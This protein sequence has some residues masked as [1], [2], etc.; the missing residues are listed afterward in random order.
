MWTQIAGKIKLALAPMVN[1]WWQVALC[2][3]TRGLTTAP[4]PY[5]H[6]SFQMD[7]D[8]T[9]HELRIT[10][11]DGEVRSVALAPRSVADFYQDV[12]STLSSLG[13]GVRIWTTPVEV[14]DPIPFDQDTV[15]ASYDPEYAHR[16]WR[17]LWQVDRVFNIFRSSFIGKVSPVN[18]YWGSFDLAI[19]RFSGR[20]A[21]LHPSVPF[22]AD[23]VVQE[24][25]SHQES[26]CGFWPGGGPVP[27]PVFYS[28]AYPGPPGFRDAPLRPDAASFNSDLAE[29]ILPYD[30]VR[31]ADSPD[32]LLLQFL[33]STYEAAANTAKWDREALERTWPVP[34][35]SPSRHRAV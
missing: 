30:D 2:V 4:I 29:F 16:L 34:R 10:T 14:A 19:T 35:T 28:Y 26:S 31:Q 3:T 15:H 21:P 8:F 17:I 25:Y 5:G 24:A 22:V 1:H 6:R 11:D 7:F 23:Y 33:Q 18:F 12:M 13:M 9:I 32:D 20:P 27:F